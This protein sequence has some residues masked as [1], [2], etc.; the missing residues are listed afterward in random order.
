[1]KRI[2]ALLLTLVL[3]ISLA[4]CG[5]AGSEGG[6]SQTE[7][8]G[9]SEITLKTATETGT[10]VWY[11]TE[12]IAGRNTVIDGVYYFKDGKVTAY[13]PRLYGEQYNGELG[14]LEDYYELSDEEAIALA[15]ERY[16]AF[17]DDYKDIEGKSYNRDILE[18][19]EGEYDTIPDWDEQMAAYK[20]AS[21]KLKAASAIDR[22]PANYE[23]VMKL[24]DSGNNASL[25]AIRFTYEME[26]TRHGQLYTYLGTSHQLYEIKEPREET[27]FLTANEEISKV[28]VYDSFFGGYVGHTE[29]EWEGSAAK[30][31]TIYALTKCNED[32]TFILDEPGTEGIEI[33][34]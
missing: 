33:L 21:E 30:V 23:Y 27:A 28:E 18:T 2:Y 31:R 5:N 11:T 9:P 4:A 25:E 20:A 14:T 26:M 1:M 12:S 8:T 29:E 16:M 24:D 3:C 10:R 15:K 22:E 32:T 17:Y 6:S 7:E 13:I 34:N 19:Y